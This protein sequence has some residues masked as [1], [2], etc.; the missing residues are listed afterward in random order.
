[1]YLSTRLLGLRSP[2]RAFVRLMSPGQRTKAGGPYTGSEDGSGETE[3]SRGGGRAIGRRG[4]P[5]G[6]GIAESD[7]DMDEDGRT[8]DVGANVPTVYVP[9]H[10]AY[11]LAPLVLLDYTAYGRVRAPRGRALCALPDN[12]AFLSQ[13]GRSGRRCVSSYRPRACSSCS[14]GSHRIRGTESPKLRR[15]SCVALGRRA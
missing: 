5:G 11:A 3:E 2:E 15:W 6:E 13:E 14:F 9:L 8:A 4:S 10:V 7:E 1:M 12:A